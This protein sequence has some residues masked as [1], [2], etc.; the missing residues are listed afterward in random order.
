MTRS[1]T[2]FS[3]PDREQR[4]LPRCK[5]IIRRLVVF[6]RGRGAKAETRRATRLVADRWQ[7]PLVEVGAQL[8]VHCR[9]LGLFRAMQ[10]SERN[11]HD[12]KI[13]NNMS[14]QTIGRHELRRAVRAPVR[15]ANF[16]ARNNE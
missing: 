7:D 1:Q 16:V 5:E 4:P 10:N 6:N 14:F 11:V 2:K 8:S 13:C 3:E 9:E 15:F 12:L